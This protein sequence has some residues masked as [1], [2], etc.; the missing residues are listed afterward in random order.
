MSLYRTQ[1]NA[2]IFHNE[3]ILPR[4]SPG[5][6][7]VSLAVAELQGGNYEKAATLAEIAVGKD[8]YLAA[9]WLAKTAADVFEAAPDDLRKERAV[10]CMDRALECAPS[11][12]KEI[13]EFFVAN[14]L[15]HYVAVFCEGA[16]EELAQWLDLEAQADE[17]E[18]RAQQRQWEALHQYATASLLEMAGLVSGFVA[19]FSR[20]LGTQVFGGVVSL[21][22][23]SEAARR[24]QY[25]GLLDTLSA[26]LRE[27]GDS[28]RQA[29]YEHRAAS[30]FL[31][32]PARDLIDMAAQLLRVE[33]LPLQT[34][35]GLVQTFDDGLRHVL[36]G[37]LHQLERKL[38]PPMYGAME[39]QTKSLTASYAQALVLPPGMRLPTTRLPKFS[40]VEA[41][42]P[43][44]QPLLAWLAYMVPGVQNLDAYRLLGYPMPVIGK[45]LYGFRGSFMG[46][47]LPTR[48]DYAYKAGA[49]K[50][51]CL[52]ILAVLCGFAFPPSLVLS[53]PLVIG[54]SIVLVNRRRG[55]SRLQDDVRRTLWAV[56]TWLPKRT[57]GPGGWATGTGTTTLPSPPPL[58]GALPGPGQAAVRGWSRLT[59]ILVGC[60]VVA[61]L[62][63]IAFV[64]LVIVGLTHSSRS[65]STGSKT[66]EPLVAP[67]NTSKAKPTPPEVRQALPARSGNE[68]APHEESL[69]LA[70]PATGQSYVV[71]GVAAGDTLNVRSGPGA[72]HEVVAR[73]PGGYRNIQIIGA[74][75]LNGTTPWVQ[76]KF[77]ER[78]GWVTRPY[79]RP[80]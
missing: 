4:T 10:F 48:L 73:L 62:L 58:P 65:T 47:S 32:V 55:R 42:H 68:P 11:H 63:F 14:I 19:L 18:R 39:G 22:A 2:L 3:A 46:K 17:M 76:I 26:N 28:L 12:R 13:I 20:R 67:D 78:T 60:G 16:A 9:G 40:S 43:L 61:L 74:P 8:P 29:G 72:N 71:A 30:L 79:L 27:A 7:E 33:G 35:D 1:L 57:G 23:L 54:Y 70:S 64:G 77:G 45:R 53:V 69:P 44:S 51:G 24:T 38:G 80:Q 41:A 56:D 66:S 37:H 49:S 59:R 36:G 52:F 21:S 31:F 75:V 25:A 50:M 34:L 15:G 6:G 5:F